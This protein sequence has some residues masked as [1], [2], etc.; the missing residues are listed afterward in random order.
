MTGHCNWLQ[1]EDLFKRRDDDDSDDDDDDGDDADDIDHDHN[2]H[3][4]HGHDDHGHHCNLVQRRVVFRRW[5]Q[6][7]AINSP[8]LHIILSNA[9]RCDEDNDESS[10]DDDDIYI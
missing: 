9:K 4:D 5:K 10:D 7:L 2:D 1:I 8:N 6:D 3:G